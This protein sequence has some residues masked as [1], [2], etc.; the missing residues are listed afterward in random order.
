MDILT[1][2]EFVEAARTDGLKPYVDIVD[3][4]REGFK[5]ENTLKTDT[6]E[7]VRTSLAHQYLPRFLPGIGVIKLV[8]MFIAFCAGVY[9]MRYLITEPGVNPDM[10]EIVGYLV[11]LIMGGLC[12]AFIGFMLDFERDEVTLHFLKPRPTKSLDNPLGG[13][14]RY[15]YKSG[16]VKVVYGSNLGSYME[17]L[18]KSTIQ[19]KE[20]KLTR[21]HATYFGNEPGYT[22]ALDAYLILTGFLACKKEMPLAL[23]VATNPDSE[24]DKET[25][26][27]A[28]KAV[29][30]YTGVALE[31][32]YQAFKMEQVGDIE[33]SKKQSKLIAEQIDADLKRAMAPKLGMKDIEL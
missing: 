8:V 31:P 26:R 6:Q 28:M 14:L 11:P 20:C 19:L 25:V 10:P 2:E 32:A 17:L 27:K 30:E 13:Q 16:H 18:R 15:D 29:V 12:A 3:A 24:L 4:W 1:T 9:G 22:V 23:E 7:Y 5:Y 33:R 21:L